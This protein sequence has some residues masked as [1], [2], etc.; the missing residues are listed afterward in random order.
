MQVA[1][2]LRGGAESDR[3][4]SIPDAILRVGVRPLADLLLSLS[5][6]EVFIPRTPGQRNLWVHSIQVAMAARRLAQLHPQTGIGP[7]QAYL[8]GLL[9]DIGRFVMF[10][11]RPS[12]LGQID[13]AAVGNPKEL[14]EAE[15]RIC[16]FDHAELGWHV[17]EQWKVAEMVTAMVR[18]HHRYRDTLAAVP[19]EVVGL[20]RLVQQADFM[21]FGLLQNPALPHQPDRQAALERLLQVGG[22]PLVPVAACADHLADIDRESRLAASLVDI[23]VGGSGTGSPRS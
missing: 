19:P 10:E 16:G 9:H 8:A 23:V 6:V 11:H 21:S 20:V 13:E 5:V 17:C 18:Y 12:D 1:S 15:L 7:E 2:T 22:E 3:L 4:D 14:V